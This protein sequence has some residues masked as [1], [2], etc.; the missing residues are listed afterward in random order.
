MDRVS[1]C[2]IF[3]G[4]LPLQD[5]KAS[6]SE[7]KL[8]R[9]LSLRGWSIYYLFAFLDSLVIILESDNIVFT[10]II[11][12]LYLC[13]DKVLLIIG[14]SKAMLCTHQN[15]KR[16][17]T[18]HFDDWLSNLEST[19]SICH[20]PM[21]LT[22]VVEQVRQ[23]CSLL[24]HHWWMYYGYHL[25]YVTNHFGIIINDYEKTLL[26]SHWL[27]EVHLRQLHYPEWQIDSNSCSLCCTFDY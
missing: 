14:I 20:N 1:I 21:F 3:A 19:R 8:L 25:C 12:N 18:W 10:E 26:Y 22:M 23:W 4:Y 11:S 13:N 16:T 9:H 17:S 27:L 7:T 24:R 2:G 15:E 5:T 6:Q